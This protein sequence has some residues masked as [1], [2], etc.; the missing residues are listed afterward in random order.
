MKIEVFNEL[1]IQKFKTDKEHIVISIQG[2]N[3]DFVKLPEQKSRLD[4]I[5]L[6]FYD[7]DRDTGQ[8][9]YDRFIFTKSQ[10]DLIL[11]FVDKWKDRIN[12]ILINCVAG[13]S[14]SAGVAAAL[15]KIINGEDSYFFKHYLPNSKVY[16]TIL[17][18]Y[19]TK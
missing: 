10:A 8:F 4:W 1:D 15:S 2:P 13:I 9:P 11:Q 18:T 14:R 12:L 7:L 3:F 6:T 19:Y 5:G 16:S 17:N